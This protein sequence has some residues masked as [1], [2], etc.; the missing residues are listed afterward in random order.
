MFKKRVARIVLFAGWL[1]LALLILQTPAQASSLRLEFV[2]SCKAKSMCSHFDVI[3][4]GGPI[5]YGNSATICWVGICKSA[6]AGSSNC[7]NGNCNLT[8]AYSG[9]GPYR[10]GSIGRAALTTRGKSY[11]RS[12][13]LVCSSGLN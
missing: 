7:Y 9:V 13:R 11:T 3:F 6:Y 8:V 5:K 10:C 1:L 12:N 2:S 4:S